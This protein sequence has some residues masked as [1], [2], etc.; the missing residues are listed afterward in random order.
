MA[1]R[2][3]AA[4]RHAL[5]PA[6]EIHGSRGQRTAQC[7]SCHPLTF[8]RRFAEPAPHA[9]PETVHAFL[10]QKFSAWIAAH[11]E[12]LRAANTAGIRI[13]GSAAQPAARTPAAWIAL[14]VADAE[15]LMR[16]KTCKECHEFAPASSGD[17]GIPPMEKA[18]ITARWFKH[19]EFD[20]S[21]H[22]MI[23]CESPATGR[24]GRVRKLQTFCCLVSPSAGS[25]MYPG[26][27]TPPMR[28]AR[29][30]ISTTTLQ[31]AST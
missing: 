15:Q 9:T 1:L 16:V 31:S 10:V 4:A 29:N 6:Q 26:N 12:E 2:E 25:V 7:S 5:P 20:H 23:V 13:P 24:R 30:A 18:N 21:A 8:D 19:A 28:T 22:Q 11:P 27:P 17:Q 3:N 14:R